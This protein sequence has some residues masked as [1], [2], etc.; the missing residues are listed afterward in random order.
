MKCQFCFA[1]Q[2]AG[3]SK[4]RSKKQPELAL[5]RP[6]VEGRLIMNAEDHPVAVVA[7]EQYQ[8]GRRKVEK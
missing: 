5:A 3:K 8:E 1:S 6:S 2:N 4:I 7:C